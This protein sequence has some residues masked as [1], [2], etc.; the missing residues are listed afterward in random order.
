[1]TNFETGFRRNGCKFGCSVNVLDN[2]ASAS[3]LPSARKPVYKL[4]IVHYNDFHDRFEETSVPYPICK[5]NDSACLGGFPR[6]YQEV[7]TLM[8]EKPDALLLNAGDTFQ[9]TYWYSLL[10]WNVTQRFINMLPNDA[11]A[12]GNHEFDDGIAGLAPYLAALKA[13]VVAAN[14]DTSAEPAL[15]GLY[16]PHVIVERNGRR[17]GIIGLITTDTMDHTLR[18]SKRQSSLDTSAE[19]GP[20]CR[21]V[22]EWSLQTPRHSREKWKKDWYHWTYYYRYYGPY[23][24][25]LEAPVVSDNLDTSA[26]P[27]LNGLYKPHVIVERNG[28]R[29]GIIG[30]ITT[31]TMTSSNPQGV[32]FLDPIETVKKEAQILTDDGVDIIVV[33]SHCG[34]DVDIEMAE[35]VGEHL[36]IIVGGHTHSLLWNGTSPSNETVS[37]PYPVIVHTTSKPEHK[38]LV[39]TASAMSKYLG[40]LTVYFNEMGELQSFDG[41]PV[42]LNRSIPEDPEI[43]ALLQ[44]YK[45]LLSELVNEVVG[46]SSGDMLGNSC[47][48]GECFLGDFVADS[49]LNASLEKYESILPSIS[50]LLRNMIRGSLQKGEITHGGVINTLPFGNEVVTFVLQGRYLLE[51]MRETMKKYWVFKPFNGPHMPQIS[52][53]KLTLNTTEASVVSASIRYG[54]IYEPLDPEQDYQVT[55][56]SFLLKENGDY[57]VLKEKGRDVRAVGKDADIFEEYIKKQTP[58]TPVLD[59]RLTII[60]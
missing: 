15:N 2:L 54:D 9:G 24:A 36:D 33:L 11:H 4:D 34:L 21:T 29:I 56:P 45:E 39:V 26:E 1:M 12:I 23:L 53:M 51:V 59:N 14:M 10:K 48:A 32:K 16:K 3:V 57:T 22:I 25:A 58:I 46:F 27:S 38:V 42:F 35:K 19:H 5:T 17:I 37:G 20:V 47:G 41:H 60:N 28:R 55:C 49:F 6:L 30:L 40:N 8:K 52:G 18:H 43:K 44:P 31:D 50:F 7:M 13:P